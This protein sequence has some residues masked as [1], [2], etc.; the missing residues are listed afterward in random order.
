MKGW[1]SHTTHRARALA[2]ETTYSPENFHVKSM[3][4]YRG[5][6]RIAIKSEHRDGR[7]FMFDLLFS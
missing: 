1:K 5:L 6:L 7:S 2:T 3:R 4:E